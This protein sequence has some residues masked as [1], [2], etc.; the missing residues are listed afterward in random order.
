MQ[1]NYDRGERCAVAPDALRVVELGERGPTAEAAGIC[2][3]LLAGF[4][5]QVLRTQ[6]AASVDAR[7]TWLH[8]GKSIVDADPAVDREAFEGLVAGADLLIDGLGAG[9][10]E[11][12][13]IDLGALRRRYPQLVVLR[14]S[15]FGQSGPNRDF[16]AEEATLYAASGLM[17]GTGD[18][19][20]EP[21]AAGVSVCAHSAGVNG[22]IAALMALYR[23]GRDGAGD[24]VDLSVQEAAMGNIEIALADCLN[25]GKC[26]RR[27]GDEHA[28]VPW[29]S[30]PCRDGE[31]VIVGGPIRNWLAAADLFQAPELL[32]PSLQTMADR[33]RHRDQVRK[34]IT[35]WLACRDKH[36]IFHAG[37]E[38]GQAWGYVATLPET[39]ASPQNRARGAFA[40]V[41]QP[42]MGPC[43]MPDA[44]FHGSTLRWRTRPAPDAS[45]P[46]PEDWTPRKQS[47]GADADVD[48]PLTGVRVLDFSHDWAGP[49]AARMLADYGAEVIKVEYPRRL[50]GMRGGYRDRLNAHPRFWQLHRNKRSVTLDLN[51]PAHLECCRRLAADADVVLE[52]S[53]PGVMD[54][55]GLGYERLRTLRPDI[56]MVSL[57][58][59]GASGPESLY[60][61]YGGNIEALSGMQSMTAYG[62][63][64]PSRRVREM[65]AFNGMMGASAAMTALVHRRATGQG[66]WIDLSERETCTWLIGQALVDYTATG[67]PPQ[68]I[69]NRHPEW[70]PQGCYPCA[71]E[72]RWLV[73]TVRD[74]R[75]W[76]ALARECGREDLVADP[77]LASAEG[78]RARHDELD[79]VIAAWSADCEPAE[80]ER[81]LQALGVA[82]AFVRNA[83]DLAADP[84]LAARGWFAELPDARL[85][86]LP[87]R[88]ARGGGAVRTRGPA[89]GA[90]N[91]EL[92]RHGLPESAWPDLRHEA[93][94]TAFENDPE[95]VA[96]KIEGARDEAGETAQV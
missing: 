21:L 92:L 41:D 29:Q 88:F 12:L 93:L 11:S 59:F 19:D 34:L 45:Q 73:V 48:A 51:Q 24:T 20:R 91:R 13:G 53:R 3:K 7:W 74:A 22:H 27:N 50:D 66:Q 60:F 37:Q 16:A 68:P 77:D 4:G 87:F 85:P 56:I 62:P 25:L 35:P 46:R 64:E 67:R 72:D 86:G 90:D 36:E 10:L 47:T 18:G 58:A 61:G 79:A 38:V 89:L 39:L 33:I 15:P 31:A 26:P 1:A 5:A 28:M 8:T 55:L 14:I 57:S 69:G 65:D 9:A 83:Q 81:R 70:A 32:D 49:H 76:A 95:L 84:H 42:G 6:T 71:G 96:R 82:A 75:E 80:A 44:P 78:R 52:N 17:N 2:G 23:R 40:T 30:Y 54:R 63:D 43:R 94:G